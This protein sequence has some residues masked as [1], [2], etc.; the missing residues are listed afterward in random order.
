VS[1]AGPAGLEI[2]PLRRRSAARTIDA[3][4]FL[5][6]A[7]LVGAGVAWLYPAY[8]RWRGGGD[9][10]PLAFDEYQLPVFGRLGQSL[11]WRV[12]FRV[13][14][15]PIEIRIRNWRSPGDR[16]MG[17]RRVDAR[18]GGPVTVRSAAIQK[19]VQAAASELNRLVQRPSQRRFEERRR[20]VKAE[21]SEAR[22][23][24]E[25]D[26]EAQKR[27]MFEVA[28]RY[29]LRPWSSCGRGLLGSAP[30]YLPALWSARNQTIADRIAGIFT[31]R[32]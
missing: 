18:S 12:G 23:Y 5:V 6:P 30:L 1:V 15:V 32:D 28:K 27:A 26:A 4:V 24:H 14:W 8:R 2:A 13:A 10:D 16:A 21:L 25:G 9:V 7:A 11:A 17:L 20:L 22:E 31:V 29:G 3:V 19:A